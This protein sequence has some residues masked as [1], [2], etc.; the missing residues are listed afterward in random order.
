MCSLYTSSGQFKVDR[1]LETLYAAE[2][3]NKKIIMVVVHHPSLEQEKKWKTEIQPHWLSIFQYL[4][5][6]GFEVRFHEMPTTMSDGS[7]K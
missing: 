5:C 4:L 3:V 2:A 6:D 1:V 7:K